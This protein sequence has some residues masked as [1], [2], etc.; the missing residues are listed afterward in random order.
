MILKNYILYLVA[1]IFTT[2]VENIVLAIKAN[3]MFPFIK[4]KKVEKLPPQEKKSIFSNIKALIVYKV[5]D[6]ALLSTD[7]IIISSMI[8]VN[9]VGIYSNYSLI[10][11]AIKG[12]IRY[13][14]N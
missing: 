1:E 10:I 12:I 8:D 6:T 4:D 7:N 13:N 3:K 5:G 11:E 14:I 9:T 2:F